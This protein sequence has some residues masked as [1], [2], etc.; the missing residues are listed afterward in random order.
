MDLYPDG[1]DEA[2]VKVWCMAEDGFA[3]TMV[4]AFGDAPGVA[5]FSDASEGLPTA[6]KG[7]SYAMAASVME[8]ARGAGRATHWMSSCTATSSRTASS[9]RHSRDNVMVGRFGDFDPMSDVGASSCQRV[10][11]LRIGGN[12][13][14]RECTVP[15]FRERTCRV[16]SHRGCRLTAHS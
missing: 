2:P 7:A 12:R 3:W 11:Q 4:R 14:C 9:G 10:E 5:M 13:G 8:I 16:A 6:D 1:P 15:V